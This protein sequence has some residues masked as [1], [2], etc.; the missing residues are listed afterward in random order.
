MVDQKYNNKKIRDTLETF[1][2]NQ[3]I[4]CEFE[5]ELDIM[6]IHESVI[7]PMRWFC[8]T[9]GMHQGS[10]TYHCTDHKGLC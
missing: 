5:R 3:G 1:Q 9:I 8:V 4:G 6:T 10:E 7:C 2:L